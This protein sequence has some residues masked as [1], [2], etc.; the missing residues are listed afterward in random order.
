[1]SK[2]VKPTLRSEKKNAHTYFMKPHKRLIRLF[3]DTTINELQTL[4]Y[5]KTLPDY[6]FE[7]F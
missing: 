5:L 2:A 7:Y 1:M 3:Q 6:K 4:E